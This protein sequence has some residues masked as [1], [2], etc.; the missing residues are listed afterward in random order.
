MEKCHQEEV[1]IMDSWMVIMDNLLFEVDITIKNS[2]MVIM[3]KIDYKD[4]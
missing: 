2:W 1:V 3:D 4:W